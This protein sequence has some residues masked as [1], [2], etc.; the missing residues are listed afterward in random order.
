MA[1]SNIGREPRRELT[2][3]AIGIL[4]FLVWA[5]ITYKIAH[6]LAVSA[7]IDGKGNVHTFGT[8]FLTFIFG[9]GIGVLVPMVLGVALYAMHEIGE[10]VCGWMTALGFDPRPKRRY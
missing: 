3:Q 7:H 5:Y 4:A 6:P 1:L 8:I 2:E 9:L 10:I